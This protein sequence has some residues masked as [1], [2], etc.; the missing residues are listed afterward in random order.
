PFA[1]AGQFLTRGVIERIRERIDPKKMFYEGQKL[2]VRFTRLVEAIERLS[3]SRPGPKLTVNFKGT[4]RLEDNIR[5]A[6][7]R[8]SIARTAGGA[9]V[10]SAITVSSDRVNRWVPKA[11]GG[12]GGVLTAGLMAD[13][14]RR[15]R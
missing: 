10:A 13:L 14:L 6:S 8:V 2:R 7:R 4:E 12:V 15:R 3:G 11:L 5:T 9:L 1:V